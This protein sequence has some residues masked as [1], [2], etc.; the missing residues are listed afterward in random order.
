[1]MIDLSLNEL[2]F[3]RNC[4]SLLTARRY[5][6]AKFPTQKL[7]SWRSERT[8]WHQRFSRLHPGGTGRNKRGLANHGSAAY[9]IDWRTV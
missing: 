5:R 3:I 4:L 7:L 6:P 9:T 8:V 2:Y 1:M